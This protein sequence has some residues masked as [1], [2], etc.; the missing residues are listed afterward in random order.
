MSDD[1]DGKKKGG[2]ILLIVH[3]IGVIGIISFLVTKYKVDS[4]TFEVVKITNPE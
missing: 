3:L 2:T 4:P 1:G